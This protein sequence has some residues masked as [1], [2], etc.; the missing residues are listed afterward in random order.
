M[1]QPN[2]LVETRAFYDALA[3][4]YEHRMGTNLDG[5]PLERALLKTF[6]ELVGEGARVLDVGSGPGRV[7]A[8]LRNVGLVC[9]GVDLSPV[10]ISLAR[11][12]FPDL[13]FEVGSMTDLPAADEALDGLLAWYSLIHIPP[14][15]RPAVL[16]GFHRVLRPGGYVLIG[17]QV[18][19]EPSHVEAP[20]GRQYP[21]G[22][23]VALDFHRLS[24]DVIAGELE[25]VGF[26]QHSVTVRS[27]LHD[28]QPQA[29]VLACRV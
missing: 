21:D 25:A 17:F 8:F 5:L 18:G 14:A 19:T 12:A 15:E 9:R 6:A 26:A 27:A 2:F 11:A 24:P 23:T 28:R 29:F 10:M 22:R 16:A 1:T 7:S 4:D 20:D 3:V 13:P